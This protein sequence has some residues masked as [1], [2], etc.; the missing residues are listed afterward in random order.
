MTI[1]DYAPADLPALQIVRA[2]A[3]APVFAAFRA[4]VGAEIAAAALASAEAEQ[5]GLLQSLCIPNADRRMLTVALVSR[6]SAPAA[7][8][9]TPR[10]AAPTRR[11][12]SARRSRRSISTSCSR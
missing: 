12:A 2:A 5:A 4:I 10:P 1:R 7:T 11:R 9:A 6:R 3:F 8:R